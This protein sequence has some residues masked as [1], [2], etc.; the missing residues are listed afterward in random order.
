MQMA[1]LP[2]TLSFALWIVLACWVVAIIAYL[3]GG[4]TYLIIPLFFFGVFTGIVEWLLR[5]NAS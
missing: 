1:R 3:I 5:H 2:D 4:P